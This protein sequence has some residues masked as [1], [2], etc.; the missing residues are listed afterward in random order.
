MLLSHINILMISSPVTPM[1]V[2][3]GKD[4]ID[5]KAPSQKGTFRN[6]AI[7]SNAEQ[8]KLCFVGL[9]WISWT[10]KWPVCIIRVMVAGFEQINVWNGLSN[11]SERDPFTA[12]I[13]I[14]GIIRIIC[15][16]ST[17]LKS[18]RGPALHLYPLLFTLEKK[19]C[20]LK[21]GAEA[22][23]FLISKPNNM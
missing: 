9:T 17:K 7:T 6:E 2:D 15:A 14:E 10:S 12:N 16:W 23:F 21:S 3:M 8:R 22:P 19:G 4:Q 11:Y 18:T 13:V 5:L 1:S 20:K